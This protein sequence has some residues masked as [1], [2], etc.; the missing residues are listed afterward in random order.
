MI[1]KREE[2]MNNQLEEL[3]KKFVEHSAMDRMVDMDAQ[4]E[5]EPGVDQFDPVIADHIVVEEKSVDVAN[6]DDSNVVIDEPVVTE[7][8]V[9]ETPDCDEI[10]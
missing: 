7:S 10:K 2:T 9:E 4:E 3:E 1:Q 5:L 6:I 8:R